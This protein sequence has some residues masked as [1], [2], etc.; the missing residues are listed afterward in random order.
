MLHNDNQLHNAMR[1]KFERMKFIE[2]Y[3]VSRG[4]YTKIPL[5]V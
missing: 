5:H 4:R 1:E 2:I 3:K